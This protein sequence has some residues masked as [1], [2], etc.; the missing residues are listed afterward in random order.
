[1]RRLKR[2]LAEDYPKR[3]AR[4][5]VFFALAN[6][7]GHIER[8]WVICSQEKLLERIR[9][10]T[11]HVM[12]RRTLNRHLNGLE[13]DDVINRTRRHK[14]DRRTGELRMQPT[15]YTLGLRGK[16]WK[17][18]MG[19]AGIIP[20]GRLRVPK[21]AQSRT[22]IY[23]SRCPHCGQNLPQRGQRINGNGRSRPPQAGAVNDPQNTGATRRRR[24][25]RAAGKALSREEAQ[26]AYHLTEKKR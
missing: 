12:S 9:G 8:A 1:M 14:R 21:M 15:M 24:A 13:R 25:A 20:F 22:T 10:N 7:M 16:E 4:F 2:E 6:L 23:F 17:K 11:G 19:V 3:G 5:D 18:R 26:I